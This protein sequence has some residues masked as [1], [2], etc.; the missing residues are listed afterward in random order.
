[1]INKTALWEALSSTCCVRFGVFLCFFVFKQRLV[2]VR[3]SGGILVVGGD[4][5]GLPQPRFLSFVW[6]TYYSSSLCPRSIFTAA[7]ICCCVIKASARYP[8]QTTLKKKKK[9]HEQS[10]A[11]PT[12]RSAPAGGQGW[13]L[14]APLRGPRG[15][16]RDAGPGLPSRSPGRSAA[17]SPA[18]PAAAGE[19]SGA[20]ARWDAAAPGSCSPGPAAASRPA[21][22]GSPSTRA[23]PAASTPRPPPGA[24]PRS[25]R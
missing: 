11:L 21:R 16:R 2:V 8:M 14:P 20:G 22:P 15:G 18:V 7:R 4:V 13:R 10:A 17:R 25:P 19:R 24:A 9:N 5:G 3:L 6:L 23:H 12:E 1:M